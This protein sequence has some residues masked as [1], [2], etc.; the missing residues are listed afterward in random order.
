MG[1]KVL[2]SAERLRMS[3]SHRQS[4]VGTEKVEHIR[5][6]G[7]LV[8]ELQTVQSQ[9]IPRISSGRVILQGAVI[10]VRRAFGAMSLD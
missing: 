4:R 9:P 10:V 8:L 6:G 2:M 7:V 5:R 3:L 1:E